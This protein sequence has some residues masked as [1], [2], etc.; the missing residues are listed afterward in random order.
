MA[1]HWAVLPTA[2]NHVGNV[3]SVRGVA[4]CKNTN[5]GQRIEPGRGPILDRRKLEAQVAPARAETGCL[6]PIL[7]F[8]VVDN[9]TLIPRKQCGYHEADALAG[10]RWSKRENML[11]AVM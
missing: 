11:W 1:F 9:G 3:L 2:N 10:P 8:D 6:R 7:T 4:R 5:L